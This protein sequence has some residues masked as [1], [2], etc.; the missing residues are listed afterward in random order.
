MK[1]KK[2]LFLLLITLFSFNYI[3]PQ[4][5]DDTSDTKWE[6]D[7]FK[8]EFD[9]WE[10]R[11]SSPTIS[12]TYGQSNIAINNFSESFKDAS[13]PEVKLGYSKEKP[14][15]HSEN[16]LKYSYRYIFLTNFETDLFENSGSSA[17]NGLETSIWRFGFGRASGYGYKISNSSSIIP[18][19]GYSIGWSRLNMKEVP[20]NPVDKM[21]TDL[22]N[23]SFR[24]GSSAEGG[25]RVK[26]I[27]AI[28]LEAGYE[29]SVVFQRHLFWKWAG[30]AIIEAA[31]QGLLDSFIN[32]IVDSSPYAA[33][34][35]N[36]ILKN[37]LSYGIYELRV[38]K[39]NW[40]FNSEAPLTLDQFKFGVTFNF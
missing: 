1:N 29:R 7:R 4:E 38:E 3:H 18:Y 6:W 23:E 8:E 31:S 33:P 34:I 25:L 36:F 40:P 37:A 11:H 24:F 21:K 9:I 27:P 19:Y 30:S 5:T 32:V 13:L 14:S 26:I 16:I 35:V 12:V 17:G 28:T 15:L 2:L 22:F 39:M 10:S 20:T